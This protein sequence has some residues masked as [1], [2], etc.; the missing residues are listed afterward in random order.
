VAGQNSNIPGERAEAAW[1]VV[2]RGNE[3]E[4]NKNAA[5]DIGF[6]QRNAAKLKGW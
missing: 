5:V 1:A 6:N 3:F 4:F 2:A